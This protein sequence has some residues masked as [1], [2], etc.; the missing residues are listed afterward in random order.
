[1]STTT[2]FKFKDIFANYE[3]FLQFCINEQ[4]FESENAEA[5]AFSAYIFKILWREYCTQNVNYATK[6]EFLCDFGN[7]LENHFTQW[8]K[9]VAVVKDAQG[10]TADEL[11]TLGEALTNTANT[12]A[13]LNIPNPKE[14]INY[15]NLQQYGLNKD[16]K[17][18]AY[19][20][21]IENLPTMQVKNIVC[22]FE[23][24][25]KQIFIFTDYM[26]L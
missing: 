8:Q 25:F 13:Q 21:A 18:T 16:N 6:D 19:I 22:E 10:L 3:E 15:F 20:K 17:L 26:Y 2:T 24:L 23:D 11:A 9:Q 4:I 5:T 7:K 12:P 14:P 1:M